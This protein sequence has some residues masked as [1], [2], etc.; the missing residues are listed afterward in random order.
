[1]NLIRLDLEILLRVQVGIL[2]AAMPGTTNDHP[3][4]SAA[5]LTQF[6]NRLV[7]IFGPGDQR[8][9]ADLRPP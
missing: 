5:M 6:F 8:F 1:M 4:S 9:H 3:Q 7:H 2:A